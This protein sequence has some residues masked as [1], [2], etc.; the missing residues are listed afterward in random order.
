[1]NRS[2]KIAVSLIL[3]LALGFPA[4]AGYSVWQADSKLSDA[5]QA[6]ESARNDFQGWTDTASSARKDLKETE[7]RARVLTKAVEARG[8]FDSSLEAAKEQLQLAAGSVPIE[9]FQARIVAAQNGLTAAG[10]NALLMDKQ[11]AELDAVTEELKA[12]TGSVDSATATDAAL[13]RAVGDSLN[14]VSEALTL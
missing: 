13:N 12:R 9:S 1:M 4:Y 11:T 3:A 14:A 7:V 8:R 6:V 2:L 10:S 5:R